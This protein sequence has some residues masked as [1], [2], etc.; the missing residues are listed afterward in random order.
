MASS[1]NCSRP[2]PQEWPEVPPW[3]SSWGLPAT[4]VFLE[5]RVA[6]WNGPEVPILGSWQELWSKGT[7][8]RSALQVVQTLGG[9]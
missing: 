4:L 3:S 7:I 5:V 6:P 9:E 2:L 8:L 1:Q